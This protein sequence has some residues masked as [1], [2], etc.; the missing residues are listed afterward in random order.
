MHLIKYIQSFFLILLIAA[1][2]YILN[3]IQNTPSIAYIDMQ[4]VFDSFQM[5]K[6]LEADFKLKTKNGKFE[7][8]SLSQVVAAMDYRM[9]SQPTQLLTDS[10][11]ALSNYLEKRM[12]EFEAISSNLK[13]SYD[14]QVQQQLYSYLQEFGKN[15]S[16]D[17]ILTTLDGNT[18]IY[19][20][21]PFN[22]SS[23][24]IEFINHKYSGIK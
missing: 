13:A 8:D 23:R 5:K 21:E 24:A 22:I 16:Y 11:V 4:E 12:E 19:G 2:C 18:L 7:I 3:R 1:V 17:I 15:H 10:I 9:N 20:T 6:E 14:S